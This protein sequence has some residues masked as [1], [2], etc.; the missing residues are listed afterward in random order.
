MKTIWKVL[1]G[2]LVL[3]LIIFLI[4]KSLQPEKPFKK[5]ELSGDNRI[6]NGSL[7]SYYDTI[8][9]VALDTMGI[10]NQTIIVRKI[11]DAAINSTEGVEIAAHLRYDNNIFYL[12][13]GDFNRS[14]AIEILSHEMIHADQY[15]KEDLIYE[16]GTLLWKGT[17]YN[18]ND[19]KYEVRPWETDAYDRQGGLIDKVK[20]KLY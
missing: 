10:K 20:I 12:F 13:S 6:I 9:A 4:Y 11:S 2:L 8:L 17:T 7:P 18:L 1:I 19:I 3:A 5:I 16:S 14:K 15:L